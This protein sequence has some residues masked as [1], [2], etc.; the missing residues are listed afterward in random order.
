MMPWLRRIW[1]AC[2]ALAA[3]LGPRPPRLP[4]GEDEA[5]SLARRAA[6][7][8]ACG[9]CDRVFAAW[10]AAPR[11]S[12]FGPMHFALAA[13]RGPDGWSQL[14]EASAATSR[15]VLV[16]MRRVCPVD[17]P[18]EALVRAVR[19]RAPSARRGAGSLRH[20]PG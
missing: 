7:C 18:F 4:R 10:S 17:V 13:S 2:R 6:R 3:L 14:A 12:F 8:I 19:A 15:G 1:F 11:A 20:D 16:A 9:A 5:L